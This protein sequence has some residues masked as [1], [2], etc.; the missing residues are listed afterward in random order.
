M[1]LNR[2]LHYATHFSLYQPLQVLHLVPNCSINSYLIVTQ[3]E[4]DLRLTSPI[5]VDVRVAIMWDTDMTDVEL[6]VK[7]LP[8][9]LG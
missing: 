5:H 7:Y 2:L 9:A 1:D 6:C 8:T 3:G 4:V